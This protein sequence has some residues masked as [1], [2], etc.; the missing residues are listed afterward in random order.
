MDKSN[1]AGS[2]RL[3]ASVKIDQLASE[4]IIM[5]DS[6]VVY[7]SLCMFTQVQGTNTYEFVQS[8]TLISGSIFW[9]MFR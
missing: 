9:T 7:D 5:C 3:L 2:F 4:Q 6:A 8:N 1:F